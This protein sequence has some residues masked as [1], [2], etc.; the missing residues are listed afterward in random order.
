MPK[1]FLPLPARFLLTSVYALLLLCHLYLCR[2]SRHKKKDFHFTTPSKG[3]FCFN[4]LVVKLYF[5]VSHHISFVFYFQCAADTSAV[6]PATATPLPRCLRRSAT[7]ATAH[8]AAN[9][10]LQMPCFRRTA[11]V[12]L[13]LMLPLCCRRHHRAADAAAV[14]LKPPPC[15]CHRHRSAAACALPLPLC[16]CRHRAAATY[17]VL[18]PPLLLCHRR[19]RAAA[20]ATA[21]PPLLLP[22]CLP[23]ARHRHRQCRCRTATA[24]LALPMP[25]SC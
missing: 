4:A 12:L 24:A 15:C 25:S 5:I 11:A 8:S 7:A 9:T 14:L 13:L 1:F 18:P 19:R 22:P 17:A 2:S 23:A 3:L 10:V 21:L 20:A 6:L 16:R